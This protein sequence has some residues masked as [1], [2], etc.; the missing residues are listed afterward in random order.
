[1]NNRVAIVDIVKRSSQGATRPFLCQA[2]DDNYYW[3]KGS[4]AGSLGLCAEWVAGRLGKAFGLPIPDFAQVEVS[5]EFVT[6][7]A[8]LEID[9]LGAGIKFGSRHVEGCQEYDATMLALIP[10]EL[11]LEVLAF[12]LWIRN[13]DRTVTQPFGSSGNPNLLW[14]STTSQLWVIDH[15]NAFLPDDLLHAGGFRN[16]VFFEARNAL[17]S[18]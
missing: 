6:Q 10:L 18:S 5:R 15:N 7:S 13:T 16:H 2:D 4:G 12:D 17:D 3:V 1:M 9:D 11:R 14:A 8:F